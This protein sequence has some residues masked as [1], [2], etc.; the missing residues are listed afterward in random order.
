MRQVCCNRKVQ[1]SF[2][3]KNLKN[4]VTLRSKVTPTLQRCAAKV[5]APVFFAEFSCAM[6]I[7]SSVHFTETVKSNLVTSLLGEN[8][9]KRLQAIEV[10]T[11]S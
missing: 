5:T 7:M 10:T 6:Q 9:S 2:K 3:S 1:W 11:I 8:S 4:N